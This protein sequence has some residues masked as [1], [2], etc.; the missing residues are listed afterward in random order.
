MSVRTEMNGYLGSSN[1]IFDRVLLLA[2]KYAIQ[3][4]ESERV[5]FKNTKFSLIYDYVAFHVRRERMDFLNTIETT[6]LVFEKKIKLNSYIYV[7]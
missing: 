7:K 1:N 2:G 3:N 4:T 6:V 5:E